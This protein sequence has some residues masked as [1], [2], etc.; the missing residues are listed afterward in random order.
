MRKYILTLLVLLGSWQSHAATTSTSGRF[1][2]VV[3]VIFENAAF[4][5]V[6][7]QPDFKNFAAKGVLFTNLWAE[8]HPSQGNY[9]AMISGDTYGVRTDNNVT[10]KGPHIGDLLE[11][12]G[13]DWKVYAENYPGN[14]YTGGGYNDYARKHVPFMSFVSV[15]QNPKRCAKIET[16]SGFD[17]DLASGSLPA[18]SMYIPNE[19]NDGHDTGPD[20]AGKWLTKRFG[21]ILNDPAGLKDVLFILT[22]DEGTHAQNQ[23]YTVLIGSQ[24]KTGMVNADRL[25]HYSLLKMI[26]DE[27]QIGNLGKKD[28]G[29]S[30]VTGIWK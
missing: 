25:D 10:L 14:C 2:K 5:K 3:W 19:K 24:V 22:F 21:S 23:I 15:S 27:L 18:F 4:P 26:E 1:K 6:I 7:A 12:A 30:A 28:A 13:M 20:F 29:A 9:I 16:D 11:K 17:G 8:I